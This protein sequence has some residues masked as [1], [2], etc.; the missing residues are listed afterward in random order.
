MVVDSDHDHTLD[1]L[2][3]KFISNVDLILT[4]GYKRENLPKIEVFRSSLRRDMLC[5]GDDN[6][7][8]IAGDPTEAPNGIP[9]FDLDDP[10][11]LATFIEQKFL[12]KNLD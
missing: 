6:L 7:I 12:G 9:V 2:R 11:L 10:S 4:E 1:E 5:T 8:A 3:E